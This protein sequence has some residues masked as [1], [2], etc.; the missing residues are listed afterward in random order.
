ML[1]VEG[2]S[3]V[4]AEYYERIYSGGVASV[5]VLLGE[6]ACRDSRR[7]ER[8]KRTIFSVSLEGTG[9]REMGQ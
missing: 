7:G 9:G 6:M 2:L 8:R 4:V 1:V 3:D 5:G